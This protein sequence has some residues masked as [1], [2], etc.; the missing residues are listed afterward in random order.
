MIDKF[1]IFRYKE[2]ITDLS[3]TIADEPMTGLEKAV[4]WVE[5]T[6]RHKGAKYLSSS[7]IDISWYKFLLLDVLTFLLLIT[8]VMCFTFYKTIALMLTSCLRKPEKD[9]LKYT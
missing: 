8:F 4:F 5:Y 9:K 2:A 1:S 6:I 3:E 7:L